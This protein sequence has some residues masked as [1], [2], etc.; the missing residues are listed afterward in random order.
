MAN[1]I[2]T[3]WE[4]VWKLLPKA[5]ESDDPEAVHAARVASRRLR[6]AMDSAA[7]VYPKPWYRAL[8]KSAKSITRNLGQVRDRDVLLAKLA[9]DLE[10]AAEAERAGIELLIERVQ[11]E[12]DEARSAMRTSLSRGRVRRIRKE[13]R[14]RFSDGRGKKARRGAAAKGTGGALPKRARKQI[15]QRT[16]DLLGYESI[17]PQAG[18]VEEL[19]DARIAVKRLRYTVELFE[20]QIGDDGVRITQETKE[21][22]D[23]LGHLHDLDVHLQLVDSELDRQRD[24]SASVDPALIPSLETIRQ[25]DEMSRENVHQNIVTRWDALMADGFRDRLGRVSAAK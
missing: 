13:S 22:Q 23:A 14:G 2:A 4:E 5:L 19:H 10:Q 6:A 25:R 20:D 9:G 21:L 8:H 16:A 12:R 3:R 15:A 7:E 17:I 1:Q 24:A 18:A 11:S